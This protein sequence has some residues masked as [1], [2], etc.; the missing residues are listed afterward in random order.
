MKNWERECWPVSL[1]MKCVEKEAFL[2]SGVR[3]IIQ[4]ITWELPANRYPWHL[5]YAALGYGDNKFKQ[6]MRNY[7]NPEEIERGRALLDKRCDQ[8]FNAIAV[9]MR[10]AVKDS[11]SQGHCM[12]SLVISQK[13]DF[14]TVELQYRSTEVTQKFGADLVFLPYILDQ[15]DLAPNIIRFRFANAYLSGVF[16]PTLSA[17]WP[18]GAIAFLEYLYENDEKLFRGATRFFLRSSYTKDQWFP[19]SPENMQH[20]FAWANLDMPAIRDYLEAKHR[21]FGKPLPKQHHQRDDYV[22]R[23]KKNG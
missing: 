1:V 17:H 14:E 19:F 4:D 18:G 21:K 20:K 9:R 16:F 10:G 11:R 3:K 13:R 6:L 2:Y 22:V 5:D 15:L 7:Y 23:R 12:Q 8:S